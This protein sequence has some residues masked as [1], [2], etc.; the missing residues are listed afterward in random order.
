MPSEVD[1]V[2]SF[3]NEDGSPAQ[4][5]A[6]DVGPFTDDDLLY[7]LSRS[8]RQCVCVS[9]RAASVGRSPIPARVLVQR[10]EFPFSTPE[11]GG[12]ENMIS[13]HPALSSRVSTDIVT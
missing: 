12:G 2:D 5:E 4:Q 1:L 10:E 3:F 8:M 9:S 7:T 6:P 11:F 13:F